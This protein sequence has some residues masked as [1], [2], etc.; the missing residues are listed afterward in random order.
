MLVLL[1][2]QKF[3]EKEQKERSSLALGLMHHFNK[4]R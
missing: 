3:H 4:G 2:V 1:C